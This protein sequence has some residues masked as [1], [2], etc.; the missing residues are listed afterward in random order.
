[1][2]DGILGSLFDSLF[3][4]AN[5]AVT[6]AANKE[7]VDST[8]KMNYQIAKDTNAMNQ[9]INQ[10]NI[11]LQERENEIARQRE[12]NAVRRRVNDLIG[13]GLS[14]TLAAGSPASANAM[15][16]PQATIGMQTGHDMKA[17]KFERMPETHFETAMY[18][19][20][21]NE[22]A[23]NSLDLEN[24]RILLEREELA[25]R[26]AEHEEDVRHNK[27]SESISGF[28]A[29]EI[30]RHNE[31]SEK[32]AQAANDIQSKYHDDAIAIQRAE[33]DLKRDDFISEN[34]LRE[35]MGKLYDSEAK[36]NSLVGESYSML[37]TAQLAEMTA[38]TSQYLSSVDLDKKEL[39]Y[40]DKQISYLSAEIARIYA[41]ERNLNSSTEKIIHDMVVSSY[42]LS[43]AQREGA[44]TT[45]S[46][47][48]E[49]VAAQN[50]ANR[51]TDLARSAIG[52]VGGVLGGALFMIGK[53]AAGKIMNKMFG[54]DS[55]LDP[56]DFV[57]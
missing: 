21:Q 30:A 14:K 34:G 26:K 25:Q 53:G 35:F 27:V 48:S 57:R 55:K 41:Q 8:N 52:V 45:D 29:S 18:H 11:D 16:A 46:S 37:I 50:K 38:R 36:L 54:N 5:T 39:E 51:H 31:V 22:I 1:M 24:E 40:L 33:L 43:I 15:Q 28:S 12:D 56:A 47:V 9:Q 23:E 10:A 20:K 42:N 2:A 4:F 3:G 32:I 7:M 19:A 44:K 49:S 17:A 6:N 13:A